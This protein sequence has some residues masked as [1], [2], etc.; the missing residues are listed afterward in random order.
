MG[1][2]LGTPGVVDTSLFFVF[3]FDVLVYELLYASMCIPAHAACKLLSTCT[4]LS[5]YT[6]V[7]YS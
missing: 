3:V 7:I 2:R 6:S 4:L 5:K 1:D